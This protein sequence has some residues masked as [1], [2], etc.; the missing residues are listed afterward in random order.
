[1]LIVCM[2]ST[3]VKQYYVDCVLANHACKAAEFVKDI[4]NMKLC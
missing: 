2:Q 1:M 3:L 4:G